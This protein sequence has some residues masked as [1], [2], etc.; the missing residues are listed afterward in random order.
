M[1]SPCATSQWQ[2]SGVQMI[3]WT[4]VTPAQQL[5]GFIRVNVAKL[6]GDLPVPAT[7]VHS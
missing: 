5:S 1:I 3:V 4:G 2:G 6:R 7:R